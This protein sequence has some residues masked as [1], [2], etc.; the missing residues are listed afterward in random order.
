M[1]LQKRYGEDADNAVGPLQWKGRD[2]SSLQARMIK[3]IAADIVKH[4]GAA[5]S[6]DLP[7][8]A[9]GFSGGKQG[10]TR[11]IFAQRRAKHQFLLVGIVKEDV[12]VIGSDQRQRILRDS[13]QHRPQI[14]R[15]RHAQ[16]DV[17]QSGEPA[18]RLLA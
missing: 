4:Y 16:A 11:P 6:E 10:F 13:V 14:E 12:R 3:R 18:T 8:Q 15:G 5:F 7:G 9:F 17:L 1:L 2:R